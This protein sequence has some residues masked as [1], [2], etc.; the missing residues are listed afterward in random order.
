[1]Q[2]PTV[3]NEAKLGDI[4]K[5]VIM[6]GDP[7]RAKY[8]AEQFLDDI[9]CYN[10]VRGMLGYTGK[11][12]DIEISVQGSGMGVPSMGIYSKELFEGY[13]VNNIIRVGSAGCLANLQASKIA[14]SINLEDILVA[15]SVKSDSN[16]LILNGIEDK[17]YPRCS[18]YLLDK[19]KYISNTLKIPV[20]TGKIFTSD[21][22]YEEVKDLIEVSKLNVI[23]IEMETLALYTNARKAKKNALAIYTVTDNSIT[24]KGISSIKRQTGLN[25]MIKLALELAYECEKKGDKNAEID[26]Y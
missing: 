26:K 9:R 10:N 15:E 3:H 8:I 1:M 24:G 16:Y 14:N 4:A 11:Y 18:K 12:K 7:L 17:T 20:K 25:D 23:G 21:I 13:N 6:P 2:V 22:F 5:T 19:L